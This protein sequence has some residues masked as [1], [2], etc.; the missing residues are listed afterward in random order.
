MSRSG[1]RTALAA[2][3]LAATPL[4]VSA[5]N[6]SWPTV[7]VSPQAKQ[8]LDAFRDGPYGPMAKGRVARETLVS[9]VYALIDP[10][11]RY[12]PIYTDV[13]IT[14]MKNGSSG[15]LDVASG[16]PLS[17]VSV[18]AL[19]REM[20]GRIDLKQSIPFTYGQGGKDA[21][22]IT[23]YDC[24]YCRKLEQELDTASVNA[25][26]HVFPMSLQH[27]NP[28]TM[29]KARDIWCSPQPARAWKAA[30]LQGDAPAAAKASCSK[31]ARHTSM[32]MHL[33]DLKGV[34]ARIQPDG[35]VTSF[36][37]ADL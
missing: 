2:I 1:L 10:A 29:A 14:R 31:D 22:L 15:W 4:A 20:A 28:R 30:I 12:A 23:A 9:G 33:F 16:K 24:P 8:V 26:V 25:T 37:A 34:P 21:I 18:Q 27:D 36:R 7:A 19:R 32:L 5:Q 13:G 3:V 35:K 11:G 6:V 17:D